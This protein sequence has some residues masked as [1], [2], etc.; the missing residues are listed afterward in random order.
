MSSPDVS[1][2]PL[3]E[4]P[5]AFVGAYLASADDAGQWFTFSI[6]APCRLR[7]A[8]LPK[9]VRRR[10]DVTAASK[11]IKRP[12]RYDVNVWR[13]SS[14]AKLYARLAADALRPGGGKGA[15]KAAGG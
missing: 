5:L 3:C 15:G 10:Q 2:C 1:L 8:G 6:C 12:E 4:R 7:Q 11:V 14:E 13:D 9:Q